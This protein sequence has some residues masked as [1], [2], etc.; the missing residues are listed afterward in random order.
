MNEP[1][2]RDAAPDSALPDPSAQQRR[3]ADP[4]VSAWVDASAGSGKTK[5]LTDRVLALLL[6]GAQPHKILCLTFTKAAAGEMAN[7]IFSHLSSWARLPAADLA[8]DLASLTGHMPET[9]QLDRARRLFARVQES[10]GG[11]RIDTMHAFCQGVLQRFPVEAGV[12]PHFD[13][14][15]ERDQRELLHQSRDG[16]V[17]EVAANPD[18]ALAIDW[19]QVQARLT[20]STF[21]KLMLELMKH[22]GWIQE[23]TPAKVAAALNADPNLTPKF[24]REVALEDGS[25]DRETLQLLLE[26]L[27]GANAKAMQS[28]AAGVQQL[29]AKEIGG[30]AFAEYANL[31]FTQKNEPRKLS[32]N[33]P[34]KSDDRLRSIAEAEQERIAKVLQ[35]I[36]TA[37]ALADTTA[38]LTVAQDL[39][40]RYTQAKASRSQLDYDDLIDGTGRLLVDPGAAWVHFKL[41]GGID[42][43][44][45][46]EAQDTSPP[47]WEVIASLIKEFFAGESAREEQRTFFAVGDPKQSIYGFQGADPAEFT[48]RR[49]GIKG[50]ADASGQEWRDVPLNVSFRSAPP[51]LQFVDGVFRDAS[52]LGLGSDAVRHHAHRNDATGRIEVW[53]LMEEED[54]GEGGDIW[55][56]PRTYDSATS[57]EETL[58]RTVAN[59]IKTLVE[60]G[61]RLAATGKAIKPGDILVLV[62]RRRRFGTALVNALKRLEVPVAGLD[63]M[64]LARQLVVKDVTAFGQFLLLPMDDLNLAAVLKG[65]FFAWT[66]ERLFGLSYGREGTLWAALQASTSQQDQE[67]CNRLRAWLGRAPGMTPFAIYSSLLIDEKGREAILRHIGPEADDP[68]NE[69]LALALSYPQHGP[70][71]LQHFLQWLAADDIEVKREL[72][73]GEQNEVRLMTVHAA[74]GLQAPIVFLPDTNYAPGANRDSLTWPDRVPVWTAGGGK[75]KDPVSVEERERQRA[76]SEQEESRLLYV[77]LTR[78]EDRLYIGGWKTKKNSSATTWYNRIENACATLTAEG[79]MQAK[80]FALDNLAG[81]GFVMG[82]PPEVDSAAGGAGTAPQKDLPPWF[83]EPA[84]EE[85]QPARPLAPSRPNPPPP[86]ARSPLRDRGADTKRFRRGTL[87]HRLFQFLP[88]IAP[89]RR[90]ETAANVL[91][92][93]ALPD[94]ELASYVESAAQVL[95]DPAFAAIFSDRALAE[96]PLTGE[97]DGTNVSGVVDRLLVTPAKVL[98]V[99]YK[100]NRNPA[101]SAASVPEAYRRQMQSYARLLAQIYPD[102]EIQTALLWTEAPRLDIVPVP[103]AVN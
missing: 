31:F 94:D 40:D 30:E 56:V 11:V 86:A 64:A 89:E 34:L 24:V 18:S 57:A 81:D 7:R 21:D 95:D 72:D 54:Q 77:A 103:Q 17:R 20:E 45:V 55:E 1:V 92:D 39:I 29:L 25:F 65:P 61:E 96:A 2:M 91:A 46:D 79:P 87:L 10:P 9:D 59:K 3:A 97:V 99:D 26:P 38:L 12:S 33:Q 85:A 68:L 102:R 6:A 44:L 101:A 36:A 15:D 70:P 73:Q 37:E 80:A 78:A 88:G 19:A 83:R 71:T 82:D 75:L 43:V 14:L 8:D 63:R 69:F 27:S 93:A 66:E 90:L 53:P 16:L 52:I 50:D 49:T 62:R 22:R 100:T 35:D 51:V 60:S 32:T 67:D 98:V 28:L 58:A 74:K 48:R 5:V 47:Q 41:D 76:L 13:V 4:A 23:A 42:H 84:P